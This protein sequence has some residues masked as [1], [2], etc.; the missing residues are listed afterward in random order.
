MAHS[1][2][3]A[4]YICNLESLRWPPLA[5]VATTIY[6]IMLCHKYCCRLR[7]QCTAYSAR[8]VLT[9]GFTVA[10][11]RNFFTSTA[12]VVPAW[13]TVVYLCTKH[14]L[15]IHNNVYVAHSKQIVWM[16]P[17]FCLVLSICRL[18]IDLWMVTLLPHSHSSRDAACMQVASIDRSTGTCNHN[19]L[20]ACA[21]PHTYHLV[22]LV[23]LHGQ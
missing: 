5:R 1:T 2:I 7:Y 4:L 13:V 23:L 17:P 16:K 21:S 14:H 11:G 9:S 19:W 3:S 15:A 20:H 22:F 8:F 18:R 12:A 10:G 6:C